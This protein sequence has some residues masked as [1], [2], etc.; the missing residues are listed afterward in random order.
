MLA[1]HR[2]VLAGKHPV[3]IRCGA[4]QRKVRECLWEVTKMLSAGTNLL[5]VQPQMIGVSQQLLKQQLSLFKFPSTRQ[6]FD[7][8][9]GACS[10]TTF[11]AWNPVY[12]GAFR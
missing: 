12:V 8:P 6:A 10:E 9:E 5:R 7:V 1:P 3:Q 2:V 11:S 4:D